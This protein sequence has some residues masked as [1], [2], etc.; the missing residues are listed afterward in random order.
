MVRFKDR[1]DFVTKD[2]TLGVWS[3]KKRNLNKF[4]RLIDASMNEV[5]LLAILKK[6]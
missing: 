4:R 1:Q 5:K 2:A 6:C 3:T